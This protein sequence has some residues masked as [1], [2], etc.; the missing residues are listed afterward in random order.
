MKCLIMLDLIPEETKTAFVE[1]TNEEVAEL[2]PAHGVTI[3]CGEY[4]DAQHLAHDKLSAGF[5]DNL[6]YCAVGT[7][8]WCNKFKAFEGTD[9]TGAEVFIKTSFH[10]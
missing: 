9:I 7:S 5:E 1:L 2:L 6:E 10:L 4:T 8:D 3:N